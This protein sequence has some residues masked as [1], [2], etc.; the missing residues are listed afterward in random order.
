LIVGAYCIRPL[1]PQQ[2]KH[3]EGRMQYAPTPVNEK[4]TLQPFCR[5]EKVL[6][7]CG[8]ILMN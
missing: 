7:F 3:C 2:K 1:P 6:Y 4:K 5:E 8:I